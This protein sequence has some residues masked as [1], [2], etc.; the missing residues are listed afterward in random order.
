MNDK[1]NEMQPKLEDIPILRKFED[2]FLEEIPCLPPKRD[3]DFTIDLIPGV[4]PSSK[5]PY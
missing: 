5:A 4:V 2:I 3:I 1:E